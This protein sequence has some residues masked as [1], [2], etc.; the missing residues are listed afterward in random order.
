VLPGW[1]SGLDANTAALARNPLL[2]TPDEDLCFAPRPA[3]RNG[4]AQRA[5]WTNTKDVAP[6]SGYAHELDRELRRSWWDR[7]SR[8]G[9]RRLRLLDEL[10]KRK[11]ELHLATMITRP[12]QAS[13]DLSPITKTTRDEHEDHDDHEGTAARLLRDPAPQSLRSAMIGSTPM[14]R[15]AG[16]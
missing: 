7:R 9:R 14:A 11:A 10:E 1:W 6:R 5:V 16:T 3:T 4:D 12:C 15:R 2:V 8:R 13:H